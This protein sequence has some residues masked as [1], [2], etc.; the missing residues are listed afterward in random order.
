MLEKL[1]LDEIL[2]C[3]MF[4][5]SLAF[6]ECLFPN[7]DNLTDDREEYLGH[8]RLGQLPMISYE[9]L[10]DED[11]ALS[12]KENFK[13]REGSGNIDCFGGRLFGKSW[14]VEVI[15]ILISIIHLPNTEIGFTSADAIHIRGILEDKIFPVLKKHPFFEI[16]EPNTNKSP[17]YRISCKNGYLLIG[18]NMNIGSRSPGWSF[19][20][21]HFQRLYIEEATMETIEVFN[22][23]QDAISEFGC[24]IRSAGMCDFTPYSPVGRRFYEPSNKQ[25]VCNLPQF[26]N[27][28]WNQKQKEKS[29]L[30]YGGEESL[31]YRIFVKGEVVEEGISVMDMSRI[32]PNYL[33][34][35]EIKKFEITKKTFK[36]FRNLIVVDRPLG[37]DEVWACADVGEVAATEIII[38]FKTGEKYRYV[39]NITC[40]GLTDKEQPEIFEWLIQQ[41][42]VNFIGLDTTD[43]TGRSIFRT[44]AAKFNQEQLFWCMFTEKLPV[45]HEKDES[46]NFVFDEKGKLIVKE[47]YVNDWSIKILKDLLYDQTL[48]LPLDY[49]LDRQLNSLVATKGTNRTM[50]EVIHSE[51]GDHLLS[52][53]RVFAISHWLRLFRN[54]NLNT[55]RF[56]KLGAWK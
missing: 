21:K 53:F 19:Y 49:N 40:Y 23:R 50:Y 17:N 48:L 32:R 31:S 16:F 7:I 55:K 43:G 51:L 30:K 25:W 6:I 42:G 56:A 39:Y 15:D 28:Q 54:I 8:V 14:M 44:L 34:D 4:S 47:E 20:Q 22:K 11:P 27:P 24:V 3:E 12:K 5:N 26:S 9:Y 37:V 13:L 52:A 35:K 46:G 38:L 36:D 1:E 29:I 45:G 10:L 2:L 41:I 33:E 18:V